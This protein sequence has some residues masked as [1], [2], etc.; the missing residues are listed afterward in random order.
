MSVNLT[1][2]VRRKAT[3]SLAR[4]FEE[5]KEEEIGV[6]AANRLLDFFVQ[7]V[8]PSIYNKAVA[9]VLQRLQAQLSE[10]DIDCHEGEF[11]YWPERGQ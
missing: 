6:I 1:K 8:G 11:Q 5:V 2:D 3:A 10:I 9:D 7:E 4:Y